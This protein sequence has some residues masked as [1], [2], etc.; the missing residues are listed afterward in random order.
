MIKMWKIRDVK[1]PERGTELSSGIDFFVP[2]ALF[3]WYIE[4]GEDALI[5][6]GLKIKLP[7]GTDL[8]FQNKSSVAKKLLIIGAQVVD[9]DYQGEVHLHLINV[10]T[11][12]QV[13]DPGA[14]L[15]QGIVRYVRY[16]EIELVNS[17]QALYGGVQTERGDGGF[18]STGDK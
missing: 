12:T 6:S 10:G 14:K 2:E 1:T 17:H 15:A 18:G 3:P 7:K 5:P 13:I 16:D 4:P 11:E 9:N 8:V